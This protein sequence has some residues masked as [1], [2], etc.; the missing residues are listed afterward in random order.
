MSPSKIL[1]VV[2]G[3]ALAL[4]AC[5]DGGE[6]GA[7]L[8]FPAEQTGGV[9]VGSVESA[10][11]DATIGMV[12]AARFT[13]GGEHVV[14]LD[15]TPPFVKV[16][17]RD[18][19]LERAFVTAGD[20]PREMRHPMALAVAG[21]SLVLVAAGPRVAVFG[22]D[23]QPRGEGRTRFPVLAAEAGCGGEW[24]AYGPSL[25]TRETPWL[26]RIRLGPAG[27][28]TADLEFREPIGA[29]TVG[30]G[31]A[32]GI[33][34]NAD[35]VRVWHVL[36]DGAAVLGWRCGQGRPDA[37][38]VQPLDQRGASPRRQGEMVRMTIEPGSRSL[39]GMAAVPGGVVLAASVVPARGDSATTEL[40]R[41]TAEGERTVVVRGDY[42]LRDSHPRHGVLV[43][44]TD[45]APRLF[46]I[47]RHDLV[48]L[49]ASPD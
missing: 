46:T 28:R 14:V 34:R 40:T 45:P 5:G 44:T 24:I 7:R 6:R 31:L 15:F 17:R 11:P 23:G 13:E 48:A 1:A 8:A 21:D 19:T 33:A 22:L 36:G 9:R 41:V 49:F 20:G 39:S 4:G 10:D 26:H 30:S 3:A 35:T 16:F 25:G 42:T 12:V 2:C 37:W 32:Y 27:V 47:S 18:G 38:A 43:S 29:P